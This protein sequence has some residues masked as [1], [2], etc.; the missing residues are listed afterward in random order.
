M[1]L[2]AA[3]E[4]QP[5]QRISKVKYFAISLKDGIIEHLF[6]TLMKCE[7][8]RMT[9]LYVKTIN[10]TLSNPDKR[11]HRTDQIAI[12]Q[13]HTLP[14][15]DRFPVQK[16]PVSATIPAVHQRNTR[17]VKHN[18]VD[19]EMLIAHS[20]VRDDFIAKWLQFSYSTKETT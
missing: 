12:R 3:L 10:M 5:N 18:Y 15:A 20:R 9:D 17:F 11:G 13:Q 8:A 14:L 2:S 19:R 7:R 1:I 4:S 16:C 6:V